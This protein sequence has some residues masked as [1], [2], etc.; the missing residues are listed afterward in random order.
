MIKAY[1]AGFPSLYE[2]EDI[3]VRYTIFEDQE[4]LLKESVVLEYVKPII[5]GQVALIKL[6]IILERYTEEDI[7]IIVNDAALCEL[8]RGTSTTKNKDVL[9]M[10]RDIK[11]ELAKFKKLNIKDVREDRVEFKK[12]NEVLQPQH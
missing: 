12:W 7:A 5:V 2:G 8:I 1:L 3:E 9:Q 6:L 10:A 11:K 4:L